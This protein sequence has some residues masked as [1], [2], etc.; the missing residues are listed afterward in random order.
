MLVLDLVEKARA[1]KHVVSRAV[2]QSFGRAAK[3]TLLG[4][5]ET[6]ASVREKLEAF[7]AGD[8][9]AK[10]FVKRAGLHSKVL[11]GEAGSVDP[12]KIK[13]GLEEVRAAC[14]KY[15]AR[16]IFNVDETGIQWKLMPRR[17]Y[18]TPGEDK[19]T[20]R[21]TKG[22][23]FKDRVSAIVCGNADGTA[24]VGLTLIGR[25][26]NPRC[27]RKRACPLKYFSQSNAWSDTA[28]FLKWWKEV[29]LPFIRR[30]TH[31]PVLLLM[32]GCSS[33]AD[34]VDPRGQVTVMTYP[35]N[36]TSVHQPMDM[37]IL[38]ALKLVYR[39]LLLDLKAS[40][41]LVAAQLREE[42]EQRKMVAGTKGL[43]EGHQP[44]V[45]DAAELLASAWT[46]IT[47]TTIARYSL[48]T[49]S[50]CTVILGGLE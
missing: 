33:H 1:A 11:H 17:T 20:V 4:K 30:W 19:K 38:A 46:S 28:T 18:L 14:E 36:C 50:S 42:A 49:G 26:A 7:R 12:E 23:N 13:K 43:A 2:I 15:P 27:F 24:K 41:M 31:E 25:A 37:G 35:P 45:L 5:E 32:D 39:R 10:N 48:E 9:W 22:M 21:G 8:K 34:L 29:F 40:T 16:N 47:P 6:S 3:A 44:H